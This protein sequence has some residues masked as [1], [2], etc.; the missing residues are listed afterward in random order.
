[1]VL[2]SELWARAR[3]TGKPTAHDHALDGDVI[4]ATQAMTLS[5]PGRQ[6]IVV[7]SNTKHLGLFVPAQPWER[8]PP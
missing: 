2:A 5:A 3:S 1:M 8:I 6:V 4:L 7:T